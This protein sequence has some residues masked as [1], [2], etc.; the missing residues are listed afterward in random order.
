MKTLTIQSFNAFDRDN[1]TE[2]FAVETNLGTVYVTKQYLTK[3]AKNLGKVLSEILG[4]P[5][6]Y[7]IVAKEATVRKEGVEY[8]YTNAEGEE[9][10]TTPN[11]TFVEVQSFTIGLTQMGSIGAQTAAIMAEKMMA[12]MGDMF[13]TPVVNQV[14]EEETSETAP[15]VVEETIPEVKVGA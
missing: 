7:Q 5:T 12:A 2:M 15:E 14:V 3:K 11:S 4:N 10:T 13:A 9:K 6:N 8:S 1:G